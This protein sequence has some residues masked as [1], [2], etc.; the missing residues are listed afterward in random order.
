VPVSS[1]FR[2]F[3]LEQMGRVEPVA[4]RSMFGGVSISSA[5]LAFALIAGDTVYL[6]VDDGN[7]ADFEAL[8]MG[9]FRPF[10]DQSLTIRYHELP[11]ELL[12]DPDALRPWMHASLE[13]ARRK[14]RKR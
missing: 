14:R 2:A 12:E 6:K 8:G 3:V 1:E 4:A 5:G 9:P 10:G 7:R 13:V 11:A